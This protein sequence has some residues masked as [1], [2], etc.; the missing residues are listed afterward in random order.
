MN[1]GD[2]RSPGVF[3]I[4]DHDDGKLVE[5]YVYKVVD[6][7]IQGHQSEHSLHLEVGQL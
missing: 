4:G 3:G 5:L 1:G 2:G 6:G 7:V